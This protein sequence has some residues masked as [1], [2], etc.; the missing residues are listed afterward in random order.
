MPGITS[1]QTMGSGLQ[2]QAGHLNCGELSKAMQP[3]KARL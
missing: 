2:L 1:T 3:P